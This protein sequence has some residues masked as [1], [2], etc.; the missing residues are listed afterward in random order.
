M[1]AGRER[2]GLSGGRECS[3]EST[4]HLQAVI[5]TVFRGCN[6]ALLLN[7]GGSIVRNWE[8]IGKG[9]G[10]RGREDGRGPE[11]SLSLIVSSQLSS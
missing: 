9:T 10:K 6:L 4:C 3:P 2:S 8:R 5:P 1:R 7:N 11:T